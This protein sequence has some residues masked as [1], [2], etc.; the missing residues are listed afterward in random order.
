MVARRVIGVSGTQIKLLKDLLK[1]GGHWWGLGRGIICRGTAKVLG[2][3]PLLRVGYLAGLASSKGV[4]I[5][6][7]GLGHRQRGSWGLR[8]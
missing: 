4:P 7:K 2:L 8:I 3:G 5:C 1:K 6:H